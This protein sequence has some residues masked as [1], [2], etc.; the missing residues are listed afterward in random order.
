[1][2]QFLWWEVKSERIYFAES[3]GP[4]RYWVDM[5]SM[6][7]R[8]LFQKIACPIVLLTIRPEENSTSTPIQTTL[9]L[10][11]RMIASI[12]TWL[13][14]MLFQHE[15]YWNT[16]QNSCRI[17]MP[18]VKNKNDCIDDLT[19]SFFRQEFLQNS[20]KNSMSCFP[21]RNSVGIPFRILSKVE[22]F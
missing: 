16:D 9:W 18:S 17:P 6:K 22:I 2:S 4:S 11:T 15:F 12:A 5:K 20:L 7:I 13:D 14:Q 3:S 21:S 10:K 8:K 19:S 1:M